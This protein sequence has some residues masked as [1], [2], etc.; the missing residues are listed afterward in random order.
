MHGVKIVR[1]CLLA[2]LACLS[3]MSF[4]EGDKKRLSEIRQDIEEGYTLC[5]QAGV[6]QVTIEDDGVV[7]VIDCPVPEFEE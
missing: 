1:V 5:Q 7:V 4:A 3:T 2:G 6:S